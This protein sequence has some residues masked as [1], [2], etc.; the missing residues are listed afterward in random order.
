M[1]NSTLQKRQLVDMFNIL[2]GNCMYAIAQLEQ[3]KQCEDIW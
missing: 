1:I 3:L 2:S